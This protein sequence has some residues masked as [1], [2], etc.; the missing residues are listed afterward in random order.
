MITLNQVIECLKGQTVKKRVP[1]Q[2]ERELYGLTSNSKETRKGDIFVAVKGPKVDGH[3]YIDIAVKHEAGLVILQNKSK[4]PPELQ[5]DYILVKDTRKALADIAYLMADVDPK[6]FRFFTVTGTNGK[7]TCVCL[8]HHLM[9][10]SHRDSVLMSTVEIKVNDELIDEPYNTTPGV[11]EIADVLKKAKENKIDFINLEISS[12]GIAQKRIENLK[13]DV[14]SFTNITRDHLDYHKDF[15]EYEATKLSLVDYL[16]PNGIAS[17][18][19]DEIDVNKIRLPSERIITYGQSEKADYR[20][21]DIN[22]NIYQMNFKIQTPQGNDISVYTSIIGEFNA[23]NITNTVIAAKYFGLTD[24]EIKH[25]IITFKGVP[26]R[27]QLV[28]TSKSLGFSVV[29]DFAHTPDALEKVLKTARMVSKGRVIIVFGAGGNADIGKRRMMGEVT[30]RYADIVVI[31]NDDPKDE[32][33]E[34]IIEDIKQGLDV[35]KNFIVIPDRKTAID[36]AINFANRD[37]IVVIAGR[38]HEKFQLFSNGKKIKFND[39]EVAG[40]II[41]NLKRSM[42]K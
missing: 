15:E 14:I 32:E 27:F 9:R 16:K 18:N 25:G 8:L 42:K 1:E 31:T 19:I 28:P 5:F 37:D 39:Y 12:H 36:A 7:S 33:P 13:F 2:L 4:I 40:E 11:L 3:D 17:V 6:D 26:G 24:E 29:V 34:K 38:G 21:K 23:Y 35:R 20:I 22:C 41:Q 30:S 10:E